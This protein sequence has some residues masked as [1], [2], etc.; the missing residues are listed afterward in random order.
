MRTAFLAVTALAGL[1][2]C[3]SSTVDTSTP[4]AACQSAASAICS[5]FFSCD[6]AAATAAFGTEASCTT[7][8][9]NAA[10]CATIACPSGG[11]YSSSA[12]QACINAVNNLPCS[13]FT[14]GQP[15]QPASCTP[16]S[17]CP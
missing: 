11:T 3:S 12:A 14:G 2:A 17:L 6:L 4:T 13:D 15:S 8:A 5:R 7:Q 16:T 1:A 10:N 9:E